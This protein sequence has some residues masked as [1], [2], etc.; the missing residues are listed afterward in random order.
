LI[1]PEKIYPHHSWGLNCFENEQA[2]AGQG[3]VVIQLIT[4]LCRL[5]GGGWAMIHPIDRLSISKERIQ[6]ILERSPNLPRQ[7]QRKLILILV[8]SHESTHNVGI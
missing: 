2:L 8:R 7:S 3:K 5:A 4:Y 6:S 1:L